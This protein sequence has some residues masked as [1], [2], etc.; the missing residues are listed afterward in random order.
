MQSGLACDEPPAAAKQREAYR[1]CS[2][3]GQ[4]DEKMSAPECLPAGGGARLIL[5]AEVD[6]GRGLSC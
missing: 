1:C 4:E 6:N 3:P 5:F 2:E